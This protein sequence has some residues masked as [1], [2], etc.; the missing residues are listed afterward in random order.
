MSKPSNNSSPQESIQRAAAWIAEC[1]TMTSRNGHKIAY[2]RKGNGPTVL[3]FHGFPTW[4]HDYA[5]VA[6]NLESDHE[7]V[8]FDFLGYGAS[9]KP[10]NYTYSIDEAADI[11]EDLVALLKITSVHLVAH[12]YGGIVA[13]EILDRHRSRQLPFGIDTVTIANSAIVYSEY[14]PTLLQ[15]LLVTPYL[16]GFLAN[17]ITAGMTRRGMERIWGKSPLTD[18]QFEDC[19]HGIALE[20]GMRISHLTCGYMTERAIHHQ[21]WEAA[22]VAL[23][24]PLHLVVGLDDPVSGEHVL[25]LATERYCPASVTRLEGV[26]HF[27]PIEAPLAVAEAIR[28]AVAGGPTATAD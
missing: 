10:V 17:F 7:V 3:L 11:A 26:G 15:K 2:R 6:M 13:Q 8:T 1:E 20:D 4:S 16:G 22:L 14:R 18:E 19:W 5:G 24:M 25:K 12:D 21:R 23:D 28:T 27:T 9:D